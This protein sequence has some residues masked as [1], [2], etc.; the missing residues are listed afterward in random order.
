MSRSAAVIPSAP[1]SHIARWVALLAVGYLAGSAL[2]VRDFVVQNRTATQA[3]VAHEAAV[4]SPSY[5][6][7]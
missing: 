5:A 1:R 2:L 7:R 3:Q 4:S 6:A